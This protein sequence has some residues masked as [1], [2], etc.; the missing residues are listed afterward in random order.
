[1]VH[2]PLNYFVHS[3][4]QFIFYFIPTSNCGD[5]LQYHGGTNFGRF[6]SAYVTTN[7]YDDA[8]LDEYGW[9]IYFINNYMKS[10]LYSSTFLSTNFATGL[11]NQPKW[12]HLKE[13]HLA[14]KASSYPLLSG[15]YTSFSLGQQQMVILL[16]HQNRNELEIIK[17]NF[18]NIEKFLL[19]ICFPGNKYLCCISS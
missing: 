12:G 3:I 11:I 18:R 1:M 5:T 4:M 16:L 14:I 9:W 8:P 6:A 7:Y 19:G 2:M 10:W 15:N 13:L 17:N